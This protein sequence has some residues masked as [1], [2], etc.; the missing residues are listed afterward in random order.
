MEK[1]KLG[2]I[3]C[4]GMERTHANAFSEVTNVEVVATADIIKEKAEIAAEVFGAKYAYADY[5]EM[6]DKVDA[7]LLVLPHHLHYHVGK[8]CLNAGK[9]V[10]MEKPFCNDEEKCLELGKLAADKGLVLMT[11]YCMRFHPMV[12]KLKELLD[13]KTYGDCFQLS[14]WTEQLT[15]YPTD[16]WASL[17][18]TLGGGQLFSHGCH[19]IDLLLWFLGKPVKGTHTGTN[20]GTPW[21][22]QEGTSNVAIEFENGALG[23]HFGTWGARGTKLR[24]SIH[25]HCTEGMIDCALS[26]GVMKLYKNGQ[27][28]EVIMEKTMS[29]NTQHEMMHFADCILNNKQP[30][31][32]IGSSLQGLRCIWRMYNAERN[33]RVADL[34]GLGFDEP[35]DFV[36]EDPGDRRGF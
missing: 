34:R 25:A 15:K 22:E 12:V 13:N 6:F 7:C 5:R 32:D 19:Y 33:D 30:L 9:H 28:P 31:T 3:G 4:G 11:A 8:D 10:L 17:A 24:Y 21:M 2:V 29:K 18:A 35:W 26:E 23:Y 20:F 1:L 27:D 14:I 16:H 36:S